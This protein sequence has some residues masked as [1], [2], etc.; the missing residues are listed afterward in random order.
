MR[1]Y[2][3]R[4]WEDNVARYTSNSVTIYPKPTSDDKFAVTTCTDDKDTEQL[5]CICIR[6]G[7]SSYS[8]FIVTRVTDGS[9][10]T[11]GSG[12]SGSYGVKVTSYD[13]TR[14]N[15]YITC[16]QLLQS[17]T[18]HDHTYTVKMYYYSI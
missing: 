10:V 7:D 15:P 8:G 11:G 12:G 14:S 17:V 2:T 5:M 13:L 3:T 4:K 6:T 9:K 18:T 16:E 1:L